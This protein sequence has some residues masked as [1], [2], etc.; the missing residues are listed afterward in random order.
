MNSTDKELIRRM[1]ELQRFCELNGYPL[2]EFL[3]EEVKYYKAELTRQ[4]TKD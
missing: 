1:R 3:E 4:V 2:H